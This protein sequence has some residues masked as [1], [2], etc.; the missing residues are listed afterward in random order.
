M[1]VMALDRGSKFKV[2]GQ[3]H[4][5]RKCED[6]FSRAY[7]RQ[8]RIDLLG[9]RSVV[10]VVE[11]ACILCRYSYCAKF[12]VIETRPA[13]RRHDWTRR[14][15][16]GAVVCVECQQ[17]AALQSSAGSARGRRCAGHGVYRRETAWNAVNVR[18]CHGKWKLISRHV[19][20]CECDPRSDTSFVFVWRLLSPSHSV[21][22]RPSLSV[23]L[24][25]CRPQL[26]TDKCWHWTSLT[27]AVF[28]IL[29]TTWASDA[30]VVWSER[31]GRGPVPSIIWSGLVPDSTREVCS[32]RITSAELHSFNSFILY[33]ST[34]PQNTRGSAPE[35]DW[36]N[37]CRPQPLHVHSLPLSMS[38]PSRLYS[39]N[40]TVI[41]HSYNQIPYTILWLI[42][43]G[44][45]SAPTQY[46]LYGR[47]FLQV[48]WPNQQCQS[49]EGGPYTIHIQTFT[50]C[51]L[52]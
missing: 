29:N 38:L 17:F 22:L 27:V 49:T 16:P 40:D 5:E 43:H 18:R 36:E 34:R 19:K 12:A 45:T 44:F 21:P 51:I 11:R 41:L 52:W 26:M 23:C 4:W 7:L 46:R 28:M 48:G 42:E 31:G 2:K 32:F 14:L 6:R 39:H 15:V 8:K 37:A 33:I 9:L 1:A 47:R 25:V 50:A 10:G 3:G 24:L 30:S 20:P 35:P 13:C